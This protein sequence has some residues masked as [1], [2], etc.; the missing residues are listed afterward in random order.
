MK[1]KDF[2]ILESWRENT[3]RLH[4]DQRVLSRKQGRRGREEQD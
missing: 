1:T 2:G 3:M 4:Q